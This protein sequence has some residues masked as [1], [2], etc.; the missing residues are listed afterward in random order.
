MRAGIVHLILGAV[1]VALLL[2]NL[3]LGGGSVTERNLE[4]MPTMV[5]SVPYDA[6][7]S[8]P[9]LPNGMTMQ[10]PPEGSIARGHM[11]LGFGPGPD[12]ALRAGAELLSPLE[13]TAENTAAGQELFFTYCQL[14]HGSEGRGDGTVAQRG[15][16]APPSFGS[17]TTAALKDGQI[18][19]IMTFGQNNM[20]GH[21]SQLDVEER[22]QIVQH[23]KELRSARAEETAE[24][25]STPEEATASDPVPENEPASA[26][27]EEQP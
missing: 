20:P 17:A 3:A 13:T 18:F 22:W 14:C 15:F 25:E 19:H 16:P 2:A 27:E 1:L 10:L 12:E 23:V 7:S 5:H 4:F 8:H 21:A 26:N 24:K 6:F 11:P 9:D